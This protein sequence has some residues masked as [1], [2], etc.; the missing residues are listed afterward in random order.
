MARRDAVESDK[1][2]PLWEHGFVA[3]RV[4][5]AWESLI[6]NKTDNTSHPD[7]TAGEEGFAG[8]VD[9]VADV[10]KKLGIYDNI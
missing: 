9:K 7:D 10:D 2:N 5:R 3:P 1:S 6:G 4:C 8:M